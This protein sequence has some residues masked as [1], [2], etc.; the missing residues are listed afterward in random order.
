MTY[1]GI[2]IIPVFSSALVGPA[3]QCVKKN[4]DLNV[5]G[6]VLVT[7]VVSLADKR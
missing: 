1:D 5:S 6:D 3:I 2:C 4:I 7:Y